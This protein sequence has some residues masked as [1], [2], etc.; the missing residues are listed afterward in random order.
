[1]IRLILMI[2][3]PSCS[4][5][6]TRRTI[7]SVSNPFL[8]FFLPLFCVCFLCVPENAH[9][10][11]WSQV[12]KTLGPSRVC[13]S[14]CEVATCFKRCASETRC[15]DFE[16]QR[17][18]A[19]KGTRQNAQ[20]RESLNLIQTNSWAHGELNCPTKSAS[21][22]VSFILILL[23]DNSHLIADQR[24]RFGGHCAPRMLAKSPKIE[25]FSPAENRPSAT[26]FSFL[27]F[28]AKLITF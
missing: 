1:M 4:I 11:H 16:R 10:R 28:T 3:L 22:I 9:L 20:R 25:T 7:L 24:R 23:S 6:V 8:L 18:F 26:L 2:D 19:E 5:A 15:Q 13:T 12:R 27:F 14:Q 21:T 17:T